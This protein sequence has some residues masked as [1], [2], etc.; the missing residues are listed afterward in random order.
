MKRKLTKFLLLTTIIGL[1]LAGCSKDTSK[2]EATDDT[3]VSKKTSIKADSVDKKK[4]YV[5]PEWVQSVIDGNQEES[6]DY[7]II[8]VSWGEEEDSPTYS[9]GHIAGAV[10]M[11]T[12]SIESEELWNYR[13]PAEFEE[14]TKKY[15]ITKDTTVICYSDKGTTSADDRVV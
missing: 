7:V 12:D 8:E 5:T 2:E 13:T 14:L 10:H 3:K 6:K 11:N 1:F 9:K 4:V 15:G